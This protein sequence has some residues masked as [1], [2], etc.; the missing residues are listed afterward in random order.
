MYP[1]EIKLK[2]GNTVTGYSAVQTLPKEF[3]DSITELH[4]VL[5]NR[6]RALVWN[7]ASVEMIL[8]DLTLT[9]QITNE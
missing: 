6:D 1:V 3:R 5:V 8:G 7:A 2:D 9:K 4:H